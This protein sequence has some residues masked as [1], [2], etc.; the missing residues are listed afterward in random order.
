MVKE[1]HNRDQIVKRQNNHYF[2][3]FFKIQAKQPKL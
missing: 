3:E 2:S 1:F